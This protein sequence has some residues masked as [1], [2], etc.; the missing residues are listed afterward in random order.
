[1]LCLTWTAERNDFQHLFRESSPGLASRR[2]R[3]FFASFFPAVGVRHGTS[4]FT[5]SSNCLVRGGAHLILTCASP[6]IALILI[7]LIVLGSAMQMVC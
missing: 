7:L 3:T 4:P 5:S 2:A 1:M 6:K